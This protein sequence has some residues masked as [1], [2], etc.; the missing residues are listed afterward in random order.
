MAKLIYQ[1]DTFSA[2]MHATRYSTMLL[3]NQ[4]QRISE[5][6]GKAFT[7]PAAAFPMLP[8]VHSYCISLSS[9]SLSFIPI[10]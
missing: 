2:L 5:V 4:Q 7:T 3:K 1:I 9:F 10:S 8:Y 6:A